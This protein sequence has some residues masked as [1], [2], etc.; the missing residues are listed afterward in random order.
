MRVRG[1]RV[2]SAAHSTR[3]SAHKIHPPWRSPRPRR[4]RSPPRPR[5]QPQPPRRQRRRRRTPTAAQ[6]SACCGGGEV[7]RNRGEGTRVRA[8]ACCGVGA[9]WPPTDSQLAL[10]QLRLV[11]T[12]L[13]PQH[14]SSPKDTPN[15]PK[16]QAHPSPPFPLP[17][18]DG[19]VH[20]VGLVVQV[21]HQSHGALGG[22][23]G[24]AH[25]GGGERGWRGGYIHD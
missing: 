12:T 8:G 24:V 19:V 22:T 20:G 21:L 1:V 3:P 16:K 7:A 23:R 14:P 6:W 15:P 11:F 17:S 18:P 25:T 2:L 9:T 10:L 13:A 5:P 4:R